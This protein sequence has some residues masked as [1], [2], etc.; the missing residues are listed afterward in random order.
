MAMKWFSLILLILLL[1]F[2]LV[3]AEA[4]INAASCNTADVQTAINTATE[5]QTVTIPAGTCTW[6]SGVTISG[7][8][9]HLQGSGSGRIVAYDDGTEMPSVGTG[10]KTF[11][12]AG[13]SPGFSATSITA[14][15][16]IRAFENNAQTNWMQGTVTS[17]S[18]TTLTLNI[19][20]TGGSGSTHRWLFST[21][22]TTVLISSQ[23]GSMFSINEDTSVNTSLSGVQIAVGSS[24]T[25]NIL[26]NY[27]AGGQPILIHD[28]WFQQG[29]G[30]MIDSTTNRGVIWNNSF[31][32]STGTPGQLAT[33]AAVRIKGAPN[34]W[35]STS[36]W[37]SANALYVETNDFHAF[38]AST[39]N[40]DNGEMVFRYNLVDHTEFSTHGADTS[41]YGERYFEYYNNIGVFYG[42]NDGSTF[43]MPNGWIGLVRGGTFV[44]FDNTLPAMVS[45]DYGTKPDVEMLAMNLQRQAGPNPCWGAGGTAGQYYHSPRQVGFGNV[46]GSGTANYPAVGVNN[47]K[48]DSITYVGDSEPAYIWNNSRAPLTVDIADYGITNTNG[49]PGS[50]TPDSSANYIQLGRDFFNGSTAKPGYTP[51]V[52]PN[53]LATGSK[54][55]PQ[56]P[57]APMKLQV[58][59]K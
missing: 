44:M 55:A 27:E 9:I 6:T 7:K 32:G 43:N 5:G 42:Y 41:N 40:D 35:T 30:E 16:T 56:T 37:G 51:Y 13:Y 11:T 3:R 20:S 34:T 10:T 19:T 59:A 2:A 47:S 36:T 14:G 21:V 52:Y 26:L 50:P 57:P 38:Q 54:T 18:G 12:L 48:T 1:G 49:C 4:Q 29:A 39:D 8:G 23:S 33:T 17:L 53:P 45:T 31:N 15:E 58:I 46:T 24:T 28:N 25:S 22:P